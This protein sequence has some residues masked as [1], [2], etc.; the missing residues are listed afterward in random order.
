ML[1]QFFT[2]LWKLS[3]KPFKC[4][5]VKAAQDRIR[6]FQ[7]EVDRLSESEKPIVEVCHEEDK[8]QIQPEVTGI[9][10]RVAFSYRIQYL[11]CS[12]AFDFNF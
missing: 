1:I 12:S 6:S 5:F 10:T 11:L 7:P 8:A 4:F 9:V 2:L 3:V